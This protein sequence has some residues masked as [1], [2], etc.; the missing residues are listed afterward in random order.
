[1][2]VITLRPNV[3]I[4]FPSHGIDACFPK[5][6]DLQRLRDAMRESLRGA[7]SAG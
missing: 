6:R 3:R 1:M 2:R 5:P 7:M 4:A